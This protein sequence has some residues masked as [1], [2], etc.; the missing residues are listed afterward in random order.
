[1]SPQ[2]WLSEWYAKIA[3][4]MPGRVGGRVVVG[5]AGV[6]DGHRAH[7]RR[8]LR[9]PRHLRLV[10]APLG[11][12][13]VLRGGRP[14][15]RAHRPDRL[16]VAAHTRVDAA[17]PAPGRSPAARRASR[18]PPPPVRSPTQIGS[19]PPRPGAPVGGA[20]SR[21]LPAGSRF[22]HVP[23]RPAAS[24][25]RR[26]TESGAGPAQVTATRRSG[27]SLRACRAPSASRAPGAYETGAT[28]AATGAA[29]GR[30]AGG[31]TA[32]AGSSCETPVGAV[33]SGGTSGPAGCASAGPGSSSA[34][35]VSST[36]APV[37]VRA[38][39]RARPLGAP[40]P[41]IAHTPPLASAASS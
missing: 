31:I 15:R 27:L 36:T 14:A 20:S 41:T 33:G 8:R 10:G 17:R 5:L 28:P 21:S 16:V 2:P 29:G 34:P 1:M 9:R 30:P 6:V 7:R 18:G 37:R 26:D 25:E 40:D 32:C 24:V 13:D 35:A 12:R 23:H 4:T 11:P 22:V 38:T 39:L 19:V 3:R